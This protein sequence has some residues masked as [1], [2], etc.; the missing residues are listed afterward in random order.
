MGTITMIMTMIMTMLLP[1]AAAFLLLCQTI[2]PET[3]SHVVGFPNKT[4]KH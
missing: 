3:V 1:L 4:C 2:P